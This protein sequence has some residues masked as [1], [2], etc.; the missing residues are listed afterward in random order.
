[1]QKLKTQKGEAV[2]D[3]PFCIV[4]GDGTGLRE[5]LC[6]IFQ[7]TCNIYALSRFHKK[8]VIGGYYSHVPESAVKGFLGT[9]IGKWVI[10][11]DS[12]YIEGW[13]NATKIINVFD[14]NQ[15]EHFVNYFKYNDFAGINLCVDLIPNE[16][17][18]QITNAIG[19][20]TITT[21]FPGAGKIVFIPKPESWQKFVNKE[22]AKQ[23]K[24]PYG[25]D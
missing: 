2:M 20:S 4:G 3:F 1:M 24:F 19:S 5:N 6:P 25:C 16:M 23:M 17:Y 21:I 7:R 10:P 13:K 8:K 15:L 22:K 14:D 12:T 11:N 18:K 9:G